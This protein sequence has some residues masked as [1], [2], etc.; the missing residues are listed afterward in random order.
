MF[1]ITR[2]EHG[3]IMKAEQG[4]I[5]LP[6]RV[7][8]ERYNHKVFGDATVIGWTQ[9]IQYVIDELEGRVG[10]KRTSY[11][12]WRWSSNDELQRFLTYF[13]LKYPMHQWEKLVDP[14]EDIQ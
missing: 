5:Q 11:D 14:D 7:E 4:F 10:V 6:S 8:K 3:W 13:Y 1:T 2:N 9:N 12:T